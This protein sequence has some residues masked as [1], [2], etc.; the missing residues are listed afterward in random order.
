MKHRAW[1]KGPFSLSLFGECYAWIVKIGKLEIS[2][3]AKDFY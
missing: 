2:W 3:Q 1:V